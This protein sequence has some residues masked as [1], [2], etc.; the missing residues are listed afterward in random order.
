[1]SNTPERIAEI[2]VAVTK[3]GSLCTSF[4]GKPLACHHCADKLDLITALDAERARADKAEGDTA[5][6]DY[7]IRIR[8]A[9]HYSSPVHKYFVVDQGGYGSVIASHPD[10]RVAIDAARAAQSSKREHSGV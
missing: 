8:A 1:M 6:L 7:L 10:A 2:K 9:I 5:R 4:D 3:C